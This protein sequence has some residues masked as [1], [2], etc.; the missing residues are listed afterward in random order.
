MQALNKM[1]GR[2]KDKGVGKE[3]NANGKVTDATED[4]ERDKVMDAEAQGVGDEPI[5]MAL[6]SRVGPATLHMAKA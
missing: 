6:P 5:K 2:H 1:N 3:D 4:N